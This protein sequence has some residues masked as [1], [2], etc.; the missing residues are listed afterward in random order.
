VTLR[1][2]GDAHERGF[3]ALELVAGVALLV[4]PVALLVLSLPDWSARQSAARFAARE[5][6]RVVSLAG[7]CDPDRADSLVAAVADGA[8]LGSGELHLALDCGA[9]TPLPRGGTVTAR[10]RVVMPAVAVP[11]VGSVPGWS[12]TAAHAERVDPYLSR[13]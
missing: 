1:W 12:W 8:G 11:A 5:A 10:V 7:V 2:R 9:G 13:P 6:A 3:A 4:L